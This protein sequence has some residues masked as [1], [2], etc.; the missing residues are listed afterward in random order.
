MLKY[1]VNEM[2]A[3]N[4]IMLVFRMN[5]SH[6]KGSKVT[7]RKETGLSFSSTIKLNEPLSKL[8]LDC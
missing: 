4:I 8:T 2:A 1:R 3:L 7:Y 5:L 6:T